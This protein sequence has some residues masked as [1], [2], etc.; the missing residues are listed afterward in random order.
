MPSRSPKMKRRILGFQ[1]RVWWPKCTPASRSSLIPG[2]ATVLLLVCHAVPL[3]WRADPRFARA[4]RTPRRRAGRVLV[5]EHH[6]GAEVPAT[7]RIR[8]PAVGFL[9]RRA[10]LPRSLGRAIQALLPP[11]P[12]PGGSAPTRGG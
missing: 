4:G 10:Q 6:T 7:A 11:S 5:D 9:A 8:A 12:T 2:C 3:G 1:R